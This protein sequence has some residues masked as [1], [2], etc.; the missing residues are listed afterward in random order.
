M[1]LEAEHKRKPLL[2]AAD[3]YRP[4]A[5]DQLKTLGAQLEMPVFSLPGANP[6]EIC[7]Q[8]VKFAIDNDRDT[9][10]FD[11]AGASRH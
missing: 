4:A 7:S 10:L 8:A 3:V 6:V 11:T 1:Y 5:V 9:I 2:V